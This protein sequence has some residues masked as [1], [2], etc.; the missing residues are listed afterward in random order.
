MPFTV[1]LIKGIRMRAICFRVMHCLVS[2]LG[3][4]TESYYTSPSAKKTKQKPHECVFFKSTLCPLFFFFFLHYS[5]EIGEL[6]KFGPASFGRNWPWHQQSP[7][8]N[9]AWPFS[10]PPSS[11]LRPLPALSS[12]YPLQAFCIS[13]SGEEE[14][15]LSRS[16]QG[17]N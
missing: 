4:C 9:T 12:S 7:H 2:P 1:S 6:I 16:F 13:L 15:E 8:V 17:F 3:F 5:E 14:R 11:A 10:S